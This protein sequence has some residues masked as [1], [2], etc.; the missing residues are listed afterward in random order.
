MT[1]ET[2][3]AKA[4]RFLDLHTGGQLLVLPNAW[5]A[6]SARIFEQAGFQ[7]LGTTSAGVALSLGCPDGE[8]VSRAEMLEAVRR[9]GTAVAIP[10]TADLEAG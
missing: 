3:R 10:V 8:R 2:Q 5:D 7:A 6:G 4:K 1:T 9:I